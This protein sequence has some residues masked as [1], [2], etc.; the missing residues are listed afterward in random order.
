MQTGHSEAGKPGE[1]GKVSEIFSRDAESLER[2]EKQARQLLLSKTMG[3]VR[4]SPADEE[5]WLR[6]AVILRKTDEHEEA[7]RLVKEGLR[8]VS[9]LR[10][11]HYQV[12]LL[13]ECNRTEEAIDAARDALLMFPDDVL[14]RMKEALT[15]PLLYNSQ[16]EVLR[17]RERFTERLA[18][19]CSEIMLDTPESRGKAARALAGHCN[20]YLGYQALN[21]IGPQVLFGQLAHRIMKANYPGYVRPL[22]MPP[23]VGGAIRIGYASTRFRDL[24]AMRYFL[25]WLRRHERSRFSESLP[26]ERPLQPV[27]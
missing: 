1:S 8:H 17:Y 4:S 14:L 18:G 7:I 24:S 19:L 23:I 25:G 21:D 11:Q 6:A 26:R 22:S 16:A 15:V 9:S 12:N 13:A 10:L 3:E 2:E 5:A 20:S 27:G